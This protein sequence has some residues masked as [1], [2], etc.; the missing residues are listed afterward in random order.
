VAA[1]A[2]LDVRLASLPKRDDRRARAGELHV[3]PNTVACRV[4][5]A[6]A[7]L[8]RPTLN[9][10]TATIVALSLATDFPA[11]LG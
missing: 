1:D 2:G 5:Q 4:N 11:L 3:A 10:P 6:E 8:T 7:R 9:D